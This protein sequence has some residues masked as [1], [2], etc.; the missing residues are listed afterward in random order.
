MSVYEDEITVESLIDEYAAARTPRSVKRHTRF[1]EY[2]DS[3]ELKR[4]LEVSLR[5]RE[6]NWGN[7][8]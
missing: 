5:K 1:G 6:M 4:Q 7:T 3:D 2:E 8:R